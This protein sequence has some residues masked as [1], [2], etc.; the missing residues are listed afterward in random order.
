MP[1]I[2]SFRQAPLVVGG[3]FAG[4]EMRRLL[5]LGTHELIDMSPPPFVDLT[6]GDLP[7]GFDVQSWER[8]E[9][10]TDGQRLFFFGGYVQAFEQ[11]NCPDGA[12]C[13]APQE[14]YAGV[15]GAL[16]TP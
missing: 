8:S 16:F 15:R 6:G 11:T 4:A 10:A 7:P 12:P 2:Q 9:T 13:V 1:C 14:I 5:D 3:Y